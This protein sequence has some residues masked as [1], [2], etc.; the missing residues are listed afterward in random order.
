METKNKRRLGAVAGGIA[1]ACVAGVALAAWLSS[2]AGTA[3][4]SSTQAVNSTITPATGAA[5]LYPG[6]TTTAT[7]TINNPNAYPVIV[8][9]VSPG[10]SN[11]TA[12]SCPAGTVTTA[13]L[14]NPSGTIAPGATGTYT[15][16]AKMIGNPD[17]ACQ[18][19]TFV[20]PLTASLASAAQ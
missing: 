19:Q 12:G 10:S 13:G 7:V 14:T 18:N 6:A 16:T 9:S 8:A 5:G 11:A 17:N 2:G 20:L 15:L 1:L 3:E 4:G